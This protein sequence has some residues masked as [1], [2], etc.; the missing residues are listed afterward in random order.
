MKIKTNILCSNV[1]KINGNGRRIDAHKLS[2]EKGAHSAIEMCA[3]NRCVQS[4]PHL[5]M[6]IFTF[7]AP[8]A[9]PV[10]RTV[11]RVQLE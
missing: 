5:T 6:V 2:N 11:A 7:V 4:V 10:I 3:F 9:E 8:D 1:K